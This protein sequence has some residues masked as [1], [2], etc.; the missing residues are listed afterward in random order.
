M[1]YDSMSGSKAGKKGMASRWGDKDPNSV[2]NIQFSLRV[3][4]DEAEY[5]DAK[6]KKLNISRTELVVRAIKEMEK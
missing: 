4:K 3:S 5:I 6:A 1:P 2:R